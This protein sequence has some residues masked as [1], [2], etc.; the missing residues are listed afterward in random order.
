MIVT[1]DG[2]AGTGKSTVADRISRESNFM[3][4]NSGSIYRAITVGLKR[5]FGPALGA[6]ISSKPT[7]IVDSAHNFDLSIVENSVV[8]DGRKLPANEIRN[9][10]IDALVAPLSVVIGIRKIVNTVLRTTSKTDDIVV[11]GRDM[12]SIV[13]PHAEIKMYLDASIDARATRRYAEGTSRY[14]LEELKVSIAQRDHI[15]KTKDFGALIRPE[16]AIYLDTSDLTIE[17]VCAIVIRYIQK[18]K[19]HSGVQ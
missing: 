16:G 1:I 7:V 9:D 14:T 2:P 4:L 12:G 11:E 15:D 10:D 18:Y 8:L 6:L 3:Y 17:Q 5:L 13:F 19:N